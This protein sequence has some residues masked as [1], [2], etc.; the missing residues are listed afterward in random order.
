M[1]SSAA[2]VISLH[3]SEAVSFHQINMWCDLWNYR[4]MGR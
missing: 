4:N 3:C 2:T 1:A